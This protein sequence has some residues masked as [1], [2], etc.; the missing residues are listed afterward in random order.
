VL[1]VLAAVDTIPFPLQLLAA[2]AR[3][4][5]QELLRCLLLAGGLGSVE[6][7]ILRSEQVAQGGLHQAELC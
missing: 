1:E 5:D 6:Q 3:L 7:V 4:L 2:P